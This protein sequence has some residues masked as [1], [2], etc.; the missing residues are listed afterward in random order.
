MRSVKTS[1]MGQ[2]CKRLCCNYLTAFVMLSSFVDRTLQSVEFAKMD[3][4]S[5]E[6][7]R[8]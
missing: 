4:S 1:W 6:T 5:T 2:H 3:C 8:L 7:D